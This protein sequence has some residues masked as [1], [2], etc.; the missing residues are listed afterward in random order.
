MSE[1]TKF[2][3]ARSVFDELM[4][5]DRPDDDVK[6]AMIQADPEIGFTNITRV[7]NQFMI[8]SGRTMSKEDLD[9]IIET[10]MDD[11]DVSTEE[12]L[13]TA[14]SDM[15]DSSNGVSEAKAVRLIRSYAKK[16]EMECYSK[17]KGTGTRAN[18]FIHRFHDALVGNPDMT[19]EECH[20]L[21]YGEGDHPETSQNVKNYEKMYQ[22]HRLLANRVSAK[23]KGVE[24]PN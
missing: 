13:E 19:E 22:G 6:M 23:I 12:G 2:A 17:P 18:S 14:V 10:V 24:L 20:D 1:D 5:Q 15:V 3:A 16:N 9:E 21:L 4:D 7:F 11:A 8:D